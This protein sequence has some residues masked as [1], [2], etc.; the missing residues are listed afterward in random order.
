MHRK[1]PRKGVSPEERG[2]RLPR[3]RSY[4]RPPKTSP[5]V[6]P[7]SPARL[8]STSCSTPP[9]D[10]S[11]AP[12]GVSCPTIERAGSRARRTSALIRATNTG[13][14]G[15]PRGRPSIEGPSHSRSRNRLQLL[16]M[17]DVQSPSWMLALMAPQLAMQG[18]VFRTVRSCRSA[19]P[20]RVCHATLTG[21][22]PDNR[23][24]RR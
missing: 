11:H 12:N 16:G 23:P 2:A 20:L 7:P 22:R 13:A 1:R 14:R 17:W 8:A 19:V 6:A 10:P 15:L 18:G 9:I 24:R 5:R 4:Q 21:V 3:C